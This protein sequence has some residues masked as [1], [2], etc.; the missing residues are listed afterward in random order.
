VLAV[1]LPALWIALGGWREPLVVADLTGDVALRERTIAFLTARLDEPHVVPTNRLLYWIAYANF[2]QNAA[3]SAQIA[4]APTLDALLQLTVTAS[5]Y[6]FRAT[7]LTH[8]FGLDDRNEWLDEARALGAPWEFLSPYLDAP[9]TGASAAAVWRE[10][11]WLARIDPS[12]AAEIET[13]FARERPSDDFN[14]AWVETFDE[15]M[16]LPEATVMTLGG[17]EVDFRRGGVIDGWTALLVWAPA[18]GEC[19]PDLERFDALAREFPGHVLLLASGGDVEQIR[20]LLADRGLALPAVVVPATLVAEL[21]AAP[22]ARL[23]V[24]PDLVFVRLRGERWEQDL[25]RAFAVAPR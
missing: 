2:R 21:S 15:A 14:V 7:L 20:L 17:D 5:R 22:G 18:C 12:Q 25:R 4:T 23:L 8:R 19:R 3:I 10:R 16:A 9:Q 1:V 24:S 6:H 13:R 11:V